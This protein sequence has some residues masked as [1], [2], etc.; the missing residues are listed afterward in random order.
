MEKKWQ[1]SLDYIYKKK[2]N[3]FVQIDFSAI[4]YHVT[5]SGQ[6]RTKHF[7]PHIIVNFELIEA[8]KHGL[9]KTVAIDKRKEIGSLPLDFNG[10]RR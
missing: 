3:N 1:E 7:F 8:I 4:P 6:K 10:E 2:K 5:G 9:V